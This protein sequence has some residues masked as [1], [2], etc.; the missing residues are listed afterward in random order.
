LRANIIVIKSAK[1]YSRMLKDFSMNEARRYNMI[2]GIL[3]PAI[4][5]RNTTRLD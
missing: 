5:T 4:D 2:P 1:T 3:F